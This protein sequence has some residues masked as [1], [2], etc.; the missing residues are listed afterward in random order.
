MG[1]DKDT[2]G[3]PMREREGRGWPTTRSTVRQTCTTKRQTPLSLTTY[4]KHGGPS[5]QLIFAKQLSRKRR[6]GNC[7]VVW[8]CVVLFFVE[9]SVCVCV[10]RSE[11][12]IL[13]VLLVVACVVEVGWM[14]WFLVLGEVGWAGDSILESIQWSILLSKSRGEK[15]KSCE[16]F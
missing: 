4:R 11:E 8:C 15:R 14:V 9:V 6:K 13:A 10:V 7:G 16:V 1:P 2:H 5:N 12:R 3:T